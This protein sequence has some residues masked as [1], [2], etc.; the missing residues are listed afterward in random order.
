MRTAVGDRS[1]AATGVYA[2]R[3]GADLQEYYD[4]ERGWP[5]DDDDDRCCPPCCDRFYFLCAFCAYLLCSE[6]GDV[7]DSPYALCTVLCSTAFVIAAMIL[8]VTLAS[9]SKPRIIYNEVSALGPTARQHP[10]PPRWVDVVYTYVN[11]SHPEVERQLQR[12]RTDNTLP[13]RPHAARY[14]DDGLFQFALRS[15][16]AAQLV[17]SV[18][19]VYIVTS[20]EI[21]SFLP[22]HE[23]RAVG[24]RDPSAS[25]NYTDDA[26][27]SST[28]DG[29]WRAN[30][31]VSCHARHGF[32]RT[33]L[34]MP[35]EGLIESSG[36]GAHLR[37]SRDGVARR[38]RMLYI[39]PHA[40]LFPAPAE[41]LPT[42]NSNGIL[43]VLH[44]IPRLGKWFL[45]SDDDS[46]I[47]QANL[48]LAAW[49]NARR[50]AQ[51]TY[52]SGRHG[53]SRKRRPL[54]ALS[55][56]HKPNHPSNTCVPLSPLLPRDTLQPSHLQWLC[57]P[58]ARYAGSK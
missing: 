22:M 23:L 36:G 17:R 6:P 53:I 28:A 29:S 39:V 5:D 37:A 38:R 14:R 33:T 21:P 35:L 54:G 46:V 8:I 25:S 34:A 7:S 1:F 55:W 42:F 45:Y 15:L 18:R 40:A 47:T 49:W 3:L 56:P 20:G 32:T 50:G 19:H 2:P 51:K 4:D 12:A 24:R 9:G 27:S 52:F 13:Y 26:P 58:T 57:A 30:R 48:T 44:R 16:L 43:C 41:E 10:S 31:S 11:G